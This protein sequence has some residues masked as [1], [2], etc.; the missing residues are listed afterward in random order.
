MKLR[1]IPQTFALG[2][3]ATL[4][5]CH[6]A[7]CGTPAEPAVTVPTNTDDPSVTVAAPVET[8][9]PADTATPETETEPETIP[10][11]H[12]FGDWITV[13]EASCSTAGKQIRTCSCGETEEQKLNKTDHVLKEIPAV[14]PTLTENGLSE[15]IECEV[16]GVLTAPRVV[17]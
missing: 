15:G 2:I 10:H 13:Q 4:T 8:P 6:L 5:L 16:C 7:S 9:S 3:L 14:A 17:P 1:N 12:A 11:V